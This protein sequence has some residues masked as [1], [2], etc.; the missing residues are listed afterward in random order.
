MMSR[1]QQNILDVQSLLITFF[2]VRKKF[3]SRVKAVAQVWFPLFQT[4]CLVGGKG[5]TSGYLYEMM[6][7]YKMLLR[8]VVTMITSF[9]RLHGKVSTQCERILFIQYM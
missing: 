8:N 1:R 2:A 9:M 6:T 3:W 7:G 4:L 5:S